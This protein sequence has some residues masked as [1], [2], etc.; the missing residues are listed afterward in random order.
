[1]QE[2]LP[3]EI[4]PGKQLSEIDSKI[5][6]R[7]FLIKTLPKTDSTNLNT[8]MKWNFLLDKHSFR[9]KKKVQKR[10]TFLTRNQRRELNLLSLPKEG[11]NYSSLEALRIM[12]KD[13]MK[14]NLD[15]LSK[16]PSYTNQDWTSFS[17]ILAKSELIGAE[18]TVIKS[19]VPN[20][21]GMSGTVVLETKMTFQIVTPESKLK[22]NN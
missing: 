9:K 5:F 18:L 1:M 11:W 14:Q 12:W 13:Y 21:V 6:I 17:N 2:P 4:I 3:K 20:Q 16:A 8:E 19:K 15:L 10:K 22:G 7:D